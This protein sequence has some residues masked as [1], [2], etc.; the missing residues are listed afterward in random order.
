MNEDRWRRI[1]EIYHAARLLKDSARASFL[2]SATEGDAELRREVESLL[3]SGGSSP[4]FLDE[5][6]QTAGAAALLSDAA[7]LSGRRIGTYSVHERIGAGGMGEVYRAHDSKLHRDVALKVLAADLIGDND[8]QRQDPTDVHGVGIST[9]FD[10]DS[11]TYP[12]R[13]AQGLP[14]GDERG[15][16]DSQHPANPCA[17]PST[18]PAFTRMI[19]KNGLLPLTSQRPNVLLRASQKVTA[20]GGATPPQHESRDPKP[21]SGRPLRRRR[22]PSP[23]SFVLCIHRSES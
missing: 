7:S 11:R 6:V 8:P 18:G 9:E 2:A 21:C 1:E 12:A 10:A 14:V 19:N 13:A 15:A 17:G 23:V 16:D 22:S 4:G 5:P 3:V 20:R